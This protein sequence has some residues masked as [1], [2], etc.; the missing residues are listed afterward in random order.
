[1][2][3]A[4]S[5]R[6]DQAVVSHNT[7]STPCTWR[8]LPAAKPDWDSGSSDRAIRRDERRVT[9]VEAVVTVTVRV[10]VVL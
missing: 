5:G 6:H 2:V 7:G 3:V 10:T 9:V 8:S 4:G 1:M